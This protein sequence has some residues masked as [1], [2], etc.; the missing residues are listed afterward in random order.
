MEQEKVY[1]N[2]FSNRFYEAPQREEITDARKLFMIFNKFLCIEDRENIEKELDEFG[3]NLERD[4]WDSL[5]EFEKF[6]KFLPE[7]PLDNLPNINGMIDT[8][9]VI[10][11]ELLGKGY[12]KELEVERYARSLGIKN[13]KELGNLLETFGNRCSYDLRW[14]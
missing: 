3:Y 8:L 6:T 2:P 11:G 14:Y 10:A 1:V 5:N 4:L 7:V 13:K 9:S 12:G